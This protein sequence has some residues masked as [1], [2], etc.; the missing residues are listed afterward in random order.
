[1]RIKGVPPKMPEFQAPAKP[2][3]LIV[4][5]RTQAVYNYEIGEKGNWSQA[6]YYAM[7]AAFR[8]A[9]TREQANVT[10]PARRH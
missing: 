3:C 10:T 4:L 7:D 1:M 6:A 9:V 2:H 5:G 8:E